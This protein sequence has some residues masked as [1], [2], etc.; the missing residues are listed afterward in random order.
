MTYERV[1]QLNAY[2]YISHL[3]IT[4]IIVYYCVIFNKVYLIL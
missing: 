4:T 1:S 2:K 3:E